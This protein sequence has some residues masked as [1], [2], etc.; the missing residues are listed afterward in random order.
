MRRLLHPV[1]GIAPLDC[2]G[3]A[4]EIAAISL[5]C[6]SISVCRQP[7]LELDRSQQ[8]SGA[9]RQNITVLVVPIEGNAMLSLN[10]PVHAYAIE[11]LADE[12]RLSV[13]HVAEVYVVEWKRLAA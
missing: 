2:S 8:W 10:D 4:Q 12:M 3:T 11:A 5:I 7:P 6:N 13:E 9:L 1:M